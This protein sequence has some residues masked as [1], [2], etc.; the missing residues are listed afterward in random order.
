MKVLK[1]VGF[2]ILLIIAVPLVAAL[3]TQK[4]VVVMREVTINQ[5]RDK[6]F[7]YVK[8]LKNQQNYSVWDTIDP[9]MERSY[10]GTDGEVGFVY[11]WKSQNPEVGIGE[12]EI[13]A[14][15]PEKRIEYA[16]RF[17]EPFEGIS[18]VYL[19]FESLNE[20]KTKVKWAFEERYDYPKNILLWI[21]DLDQMLG[22]NFEDGL[23]N[24]KNIMEK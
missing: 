21:I 16:L 5:P 17:K 11:S 7:E 23:N 20:S 4:D 3:F 12:Q 13:L 14:I 18:D 2:I 22:Q 9:N 19:E 6:V 10:S 8:Y 1:I 24:L 15:E